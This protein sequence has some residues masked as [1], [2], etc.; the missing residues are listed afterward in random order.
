MQGREPVI[1]RSSSENFL[2]DDVSIMIA[3][4]KKTKEY[5][6]VVNLLK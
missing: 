2:P 1:V 4:N 3:R 6:R 5:I